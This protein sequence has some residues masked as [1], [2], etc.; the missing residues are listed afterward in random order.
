MKKHIIIKWLILTVALCNPLNAVIHETEWTID[1]SVQ[2]SDL[3]GDQITITPAHGNRC[4]ISG[5]LN[6]NNNEPFIWLDSDSTILYQTTFSDPDEFLFHGD[7]WSFDKNTCVVHTLNSST[8]LHTREF[9]RLNGG[10]GVDV[11]LLHTWTNGD[12]NFSPKMMT[13][14]RSFKP[15]YRIYFFDKPTSTLKAIKINSSLNNTSLAV[16]TAAGYSGTNFVINWQSESGIQYQVEKSTDLITWINEG[17]EISGTGGELSYSV[18][19][20]DPIFLRITIP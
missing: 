12:I 7:T 8:L 19:F 15:K 18:P 10:G 16:T 11:E 6:S 20:A 4:I 14:G 3:F 5:V 17:G 1:L 9:W 13:K 2:L